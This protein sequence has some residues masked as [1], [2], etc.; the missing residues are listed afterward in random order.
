MDDEPGELTIE[1]L[2]RCLQDLKDGEPT[3]LAYY[4]VG[5]DETKAWLENFVLAAMRPDGTVRLID[6]PWW[7]PS[8][9]PVEIDED[10]PP[11]MIVAKNSKGEA[12]QVM[13]LTA[14]KVTCLDLVEARKHLQKT[15]FSD[16][17]WNWE[18]R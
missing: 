17:W 14:D 10:V 12:L 15:L 9:P 18:R 6:P 1:V 4:S 2:E 13:L 5:D 11:R 8:I 3:R 16:R 7:F